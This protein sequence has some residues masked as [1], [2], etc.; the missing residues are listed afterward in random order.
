MIHLNLFMPEIEKDRRNRLVTELT[1]TLAKVMH[2]STEG[3]ESLSIYLDTYKKGDMAINGHFLNGK[4]KMAVNVLEVHGTVMP[5][6]LKRHMAQE[7]TNTFC[8]VLGLDKKHRQNVRVTFVE[9]AAHNIAMG[10]M[11]IDEL[12]PTRL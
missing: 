4:S 7:M 3:R 10:G 5:Q 6:E 1:D 8:K 12:H 11:M 9:H 2:L